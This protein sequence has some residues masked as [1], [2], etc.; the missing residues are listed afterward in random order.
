MELFG[1]REGER[2]PARERRLDDTIVQVTLEEGFPKLTESIPDVHFT[3]E[4]V[5][6]NDGLTQKIIGLLGESVGNGSL[7]VTILIPVQDRRRK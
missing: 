7:Q 2:E 6:L 1:Y 4:R 5:H 3:A